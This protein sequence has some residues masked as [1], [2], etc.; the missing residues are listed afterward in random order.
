MISDICEFQFDNL[1]YPL[2][3]SAD[4]SDEKIHA[5]LFSVELPEAAFA[6]KLPCISL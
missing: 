4:F 1:R 5:S 2:R 3:F 6:D